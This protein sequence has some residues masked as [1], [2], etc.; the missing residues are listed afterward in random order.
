M[1]KYIC[2][3]EKRENFMKSG[4]IKEDLMVIYH[5]SDPARP[6]EE[7]F[8][9]TYGVNK[10]V[11]FY[12]IEGEATA[13]NGAQTYQMNAGDLMIVDLH[14]AFGYQIETDNY[15]VMYASIHP[16]LLAES[17]ADDKAITRAFER[18]P[19]G[20]CV[21]NCK[22]EKLDFIPA[23][24][25]S[26]V[27]C[28]SE[29]LGRTHVLP[30][31]KAIVSELCMYYDKKYDFEANATDSVPVKVFKYVNRN[32]LQNITYQT[33]MDEFFVSKPVIN[34]IIHNYTGKTLREYI[35]YLRLN[36]AVNS[37]GGGKSM[38]AVAKLSGFSNYSTFYRAYVREFGEPPTKQHKLKPDYWPLTK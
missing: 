4:Y 37:M 12:V 25:K 22:S 19:I 20:K 1:V 14:N 33:I 38:K 31:V 6:D 7:N 13:R 21:I 5:Y 26:I 29:H 32:Y 2:N 35:E 8:R 11:F 36:D 30:R 9:K 27:E 18:I 28:I 3:K 23:C 10:Y 15:K 34:T 24:V 17:D 16:T